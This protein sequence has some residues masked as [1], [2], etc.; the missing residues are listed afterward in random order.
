MLHLLYLGSPYQEAIASLTSSLISGLKEFTTVVESP[1]RPWSSRSCF[2]AT[3]S[4]QV[5]TTRAVL[6]YFTVHNPN[7]AVLLHYSQPEQ[8]CTTSLFTT[9]AVLYYFTI[10]NPS[11]AVLLHYSQP[12]LCVLLHYSQPERWCTTSLFTTLC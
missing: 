10:H 6:Y 8:C 11:G 12:E 7:G 4:I 5:F 3:P 9:R 1:T 2:E